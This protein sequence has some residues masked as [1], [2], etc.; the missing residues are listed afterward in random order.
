MDIHASGRT[1]AKV[2]AL[3]QK[4]HFYLETKITTEKLQKGI[5]SLLPEDIYIKK[6]EEVPEDF[7]A[8]FNAI[9]KEYIYQINMGEYNP[10]E[11]NYVYQYNQKLD[12]V[13]MC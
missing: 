2:H 12:V 8:R 6:I 9:G 4:A 10:L 13:E 1:D 11:R 7:H 5:N 3:N